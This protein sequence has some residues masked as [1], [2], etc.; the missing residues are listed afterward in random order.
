MIVQAHW[1]VTDKTGESI[2]IENE[3]TKIIEEY[4]TEIKVHD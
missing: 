2:V 3:F 1:I 4:I